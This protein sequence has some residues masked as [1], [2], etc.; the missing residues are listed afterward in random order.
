VSVYS[1]IAVLQGTHSFH[2]F[3]VVVVVVVWR[4]GLAM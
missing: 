2:S 3:V 4:Q 1:S